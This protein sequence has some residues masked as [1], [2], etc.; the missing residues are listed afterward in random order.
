MLKKRHTVTSAVRKFWKDDG[1]VEKAWRL[2]LQAET[3][4]V[5]LLDGLGKE[6]GLVLGEAVY[7]GEW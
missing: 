7:S 4:H 6:G 3:L 5:Q 1:L 2:R